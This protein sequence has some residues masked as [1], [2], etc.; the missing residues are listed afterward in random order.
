MEEVID[1]Y[2]FKYFDED[3]S[4]IEK[5]PLDDYLRYKENRGRER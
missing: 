5:E 2:V 3:I 4:V 1:N